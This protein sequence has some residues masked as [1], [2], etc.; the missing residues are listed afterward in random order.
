MSPSPSSEG[1]QPK[2]SAGADAPA[3]SALPVDARPRRPSCLRRRHPRPWRA[4]AP[5]AP[6]GAADSGSDAQGLQQVPGSSTGSGASSA[7]AHQEHPARSHRP[8]RPT[9]S[10]PT[11]DGRV[12]APSEGVGRDRGHRRAR[13]TPVARP[14]SAQPRGADRTE[15]HPT[16]APGHPALVLDGAP[17]EPT[18]D[19]RGWSLQV[20]LPAVVGLV[21]IAVLALWRRPRPDP[22]AEP[23]PGQPPAGHGTSAPRASK[24]AR[25]DAVDDLARAA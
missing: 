15:A 2:P 7:S 12:R 23:S 16:A 11:H 19:E 1:G 4:R 9:P 21:A 6:S 10:G 24:H 13:T 8:G 14:K 17:S 22:G 3:D 5:L 18:E 25:L 20:W